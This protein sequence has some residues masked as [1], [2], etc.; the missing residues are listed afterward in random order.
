MRFGQ[1]DR[2]STE[3]H[4]MLQALLANSPGMVP[5]ALGG[6]QPQLEECRQRWLVRGQR[7]ENRGVPG[8]IPGLAIT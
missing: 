1:V 5:A 6:E 4:A 3:W 2:L 8:S 7:L